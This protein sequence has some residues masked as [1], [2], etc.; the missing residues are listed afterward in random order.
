MM[1]TKFFLLLSVALILLY[2]PA[3]TMAQEDRI[4]VLANSI[5]YELSSDFFEFL[6][7]KAMK[8]IRVDASNFDEYK[9]EKFIVILGGPDA[10]EGVGDVVRQVL[11]SN[12]QSYLRTPG[13]RRMYVKTNIWIEG[14]RVSVI[15]GY[16]RYQTQTA[17]DGN[18]VRLYQNFLDLG[19]DPALTKKR[20][21]M[22]DANLKG[23]DIRDERVLEVMGRV[24]RHK[25]VRE[26]DQSTA[27]A[28]HPLPIAEGQTI[29]QPYV[30]ALMTQ[31]LQ[32]GGQEKVLEIGTG[33]GYQATILAEL[34]EEV[35]T[36]EIREK[37]ASS[38]EE[39]LAGLGYN[40]VHVKHAD[41]YF[42]WEEHGPFDAIM[43]TAAVNHI[44]PPLIE[45]L[46]DGGKLILPLGSTVYFQTLTL[47]EKKDGELTAT[48][49]TS[50]IFVPMTGEAQ[51]GG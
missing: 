46:K 47:I 38:A 45:Q 34:V 10:Y 42:G 29:S 18:G 16:N 5:D 25:F 41:G 26:G 15:A 11:G 13:K 37:L 12:E 17:G 50:V 35:Y 31:A 6:G 32:L 28:D 2:A 27:Y 21:Y 30:V 24:P 23:R 19:E 7:N 9:K 48:H 39:R 33:S 3:P 44:P 51:K 36:I 49:I 22:V 1:R 43:I 14:Q 40:N 20:N 4:V 8:V